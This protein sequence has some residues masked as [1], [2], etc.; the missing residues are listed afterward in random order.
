VKKYWDLKVDE[1]Y[2]NLDDNT[3]YSKIKDLFF[4]TL[5]LHTVSDVEV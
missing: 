2:K 1:R 3:L 5:K 4:D